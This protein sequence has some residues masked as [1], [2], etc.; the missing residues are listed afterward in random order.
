[1]FIRSYLLVREQTT[2]GETGDYVALNQLLSSIAP[3]VNLLLTI[4]I[5][6]HWPSSCP[7]FH[8]TGHVGP[9]RFAQK[10]DK[11]LASR[12]GNHLLGGWTS[13]FL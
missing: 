5:L 1:M 6:S 8:P 11:T 7:A 9:A 2:A 10:W 3:P 12:K 13:R 4:H